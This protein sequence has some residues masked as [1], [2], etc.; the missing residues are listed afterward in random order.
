MSDLLSRIKALLTWSGL[1]SAAFA[2]EIEVA[3]PVISHIISA[4]NKASL[5]VVQKILKRFSEVSPVW[6]LLGE[7]EMLKELEIQSVSINSHQ[8]GAFL[9]EEDA[10]RNVLHD[11]VQ[12]GERAAVKVKHDSISGNKVLKKVILCY[13]DGSFES[14]DP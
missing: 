12:I 2:D 5:E 11:K 7:G 3:R 6:L 14:F 1:G 13:S 4:R 9:P 8:A 10:T